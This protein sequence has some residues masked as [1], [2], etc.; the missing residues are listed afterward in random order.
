MWSRLAGSIARGFRWDKPVQCRDMS[1]YVPAATDPRKAGQT[2]H[3]SLEDVPMSRLQWSAKTIHIASSVA[4]GCGA[5]RQTAAKVNVYASA[6]LASPP[7]LVAEVALREEKLFA[8][9]DAIR[10]ARPY[11]P[12]PQDTRPAIPAEPFRR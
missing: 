2:G 6:G 1:H 3:P 5:R 4:Q 9:V 7:E 10:N 8:R 11:D 12:G